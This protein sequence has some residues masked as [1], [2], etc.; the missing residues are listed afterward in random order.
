MSGFDEY[1]AY[2]VLAEETESEEEPESSKPKM[3]D[4]EE[5][6]DKGDKE[7]INDEGEMEDEAEEERLK[8]QDQS[9]IS[10]GSGIVSAQPGGGEEHQ[11]TQSRH[12]HHHRSFTDFVQSFSMTSLE[13]GARR[14]TAMPA[15]MKARDVT[16]IHGPIKVSPNFSQ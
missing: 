1:V 6:D 12:S 3:E 7:E 5:M 15:K 14:S 13:G 8:A 11:K 4:K 16:E 10:A 9:I 2:E